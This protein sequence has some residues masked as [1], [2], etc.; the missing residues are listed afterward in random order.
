MFSSEKSSEFICKN[1][2]LKN[3]IKYFCPIKFCRSSLPEWIIREL[4]VTE[5]AN[6]HP[7]NT[8]SAP[9]LILM[10]NYLH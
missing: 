10:K 7:E 1:L 3:L 9:A 4:S 2:R 8:A 5:C 6:I